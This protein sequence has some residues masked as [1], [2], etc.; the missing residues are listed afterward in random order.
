MIEIIQAEA[1]HIPE[2]KDIFW[3]FAVFHQNVEAAFT[4]GDDAIENLETNILKKHMGSEDGLVLVAVDNNK[5]VGFS[6]SEVQE[7]WPGFKCEKYGHI[8]MMAVTADYRRKGLAKKML[9][10][11]I[12]WFHSKKLSRA[13]MDLVT[14][15]KTAAS[16]WGKQGFITY[17][18]R[19]YKE[20]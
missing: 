8:S 3:E 20:I 19:M 10:K 1:K 16:F 18:Q 13:E 6:I 2:I 14:N 4:Q 5:V 7:P 11:I 12:E 9:D 15:N 17:T